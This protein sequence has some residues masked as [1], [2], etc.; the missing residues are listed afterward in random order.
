MVRQSFR[1]NSEA[2]DSDPHEFSKC[3]FIIIMDNLRSETYRVFLSAF[4]DTWH[5]LCEFHDFLKNS[6]FDGADQGDKEMRYPE[7][8]NSRMD[9][10]KDFFGGM[11]CFVEQRLDLFARSPSTSLCLAAN[12][13]TSNKS[14]PI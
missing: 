8:G 2:G 10:S 7:M 12:S 3:L 4:C 14:L 6:S 11:I 13:I 9:N 5:S 1:R